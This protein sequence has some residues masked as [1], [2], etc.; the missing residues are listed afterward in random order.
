MGIIKSTNE[1]VN[2]QYIHAN[3]AIKYLHYI[4]EDKNMTYTEVAKFL[5]RNNFPTYVV[6]KSYSKHI[7]DSYHIILDNGFDKIKKEFYSKET[8]TFLSYVITDSNVTWLDG[9]G[10]SQEFNLYWK[11]SDFRNW[12][13]HTL[14]DNSEL[15]DIEEGCCTHIAEPFDIDEWLPDINETIAKIEAKELQLLNKQLEEYREASIHNNFATEQESSP[16]SQAKRAENKQAE[17]IAALAIMYTKTDC[18]KPYEAAE[19]IRQ[20]WERQAD[21][22]GKPPSEETLVKYIKQGLERLKS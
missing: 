5:M 18:S 2:N 8:Y 20:E 6:D 7:D 9:W 4:E 19:T 11:I 16:I 21:K 22:L 14:A 3:N 15:V 17:I 1:A 12:L 13:C 10:F